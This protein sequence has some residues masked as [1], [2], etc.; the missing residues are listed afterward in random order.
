M[1]MEISITPGSFGSD[2]KSKVSAA[3]EHLLIGQ[4]AKMQSLKKMLSML[5]PTNSPVMILGETGS[6]KEVVAQAL[7][8]ASQRKGQFVAINCAAIPSELLESE[9]FGHEKGAFTGAERQRIGSFEQ[10]QGG[11]IFLDEIG[12]MPAE[13]QTKLLRVIETKKIRRV[14]GSSDIVIDF[15]LVA[16]THRDLDARVKEGKFREDLMYRLAVFPVQV[17]TLAER[18][19]DLP[20]LIKHMISKFVPSADTAMEPHFSLDAMRV[21]GSYAW[22]GNVR[23]LRNVIERA[24]VF[25][26]GQMINADQVM[27]NLIESQMPSF[28]INESV[29]SD[30]V[31]PTGCLPRPETFKN[32]LEAGEKLDIRRYLS[33]IEAA[34]IETALGLQNGNVSSAAETLGLQRTTLIEKM[35]KLSITRDQA[36]S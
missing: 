7:H 18:T 23:E 20:V 29:V 5:A 30:S 10:A 22:P 34:L 21:L 32:T 12:D 1:D 27:N 25:F 17:P 4:S 16:A 6:G 36:A 26:P 15:R 35:K 31:E 33:D 3:I 13:L 14:G 19:A 2:Q 9:L 8:L 24:V 11:T 28:S